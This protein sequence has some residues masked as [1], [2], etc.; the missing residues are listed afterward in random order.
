MLSAFVE[1]FLVARSYSKQ[2]LRQRRSV[3]TRFVG[4][5]GDVEPRKLTHGIVLMWWA[6]LAELAPASRQAHLSAV[7]A[8]LAHLITIG[9]LDH[10]PSVSIVR[11]VVAL[12]PPVTIPATQ[13][14]A[15]LLSI[16]HPR[17]RAAAA[18]MLGCGL[19]SGDVVRVDVENVG[20]ETQIL[21]VKVKG[22]RERMVP[23]PRATVESISDYLAH[24]PATSGPLVRT[25]GGDR[26]PAQQL[27]NRLTTALYAAGIK[28]GPHDGRSSHVLR[29]TCATMLLES[30]ASIRQVQTVLGHSSLAS[31]QRYLA[32][33]ET[34][35]LVDVVERGP[36][37]ALAAS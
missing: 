30:G 33:P 21:R 20:L 29:R 35:S 23:M 16:D 6:G 22:D 19:R 32:A 17:D 11:P 37:A 24:S 8:F 26:M 7:R 36:L 34:A 25:A 31:T 4:A 13:V 15:L 28:H 9:E 2:S 12:R 1:G 3:L 14:V 27:R 10:D 18:L 5:V